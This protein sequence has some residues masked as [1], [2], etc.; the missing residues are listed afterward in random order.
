MLLVQVRHDFSVLIDP[1]SYHSFSCLLELWSLALL[2]LVF[3]LFLLDFFDEFVLFKLMHQVEASLSNITALYIYIF[4]AINFRK[5]DIWLRHY[6][7]HL[8]RI[9]ISSFRPR[10]LLQY[11]LPDTTLP[12]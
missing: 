7:V 3:L 11:R 5:N 9:M 1:N 10:S 8:I 4:G 12:H 6:A 2:W